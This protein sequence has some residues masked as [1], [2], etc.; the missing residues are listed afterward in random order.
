MNTKSCC[1]CKEQKELELFAKNRNNK[2]GR[3]ARCRACSKIYKE[4]WDK[5]NTE[6]I[7]D[8]SLKYKNNPDVILRRRERHLMQYQD[9]IVREKL[10]E[11]NRIRRRQ[12]PAKIKQRENERL[13]RLNNPNYRIRQNLNNRL[14]YLLFNSKKD[15]IVSYLGCPIKD[16]IKH[17]ESTWK[18]GMN[19]SNYGRKNGN[20]QIDHIIPLASF[21]LTREEEVNKAFHFTNTQALW[22]IDNLRKGDKLDF[23]IPEITK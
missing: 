4:K 16:F 8:Y 20:W 6:H 5:E 1:V 10:L 18:D 7:K 3:N 14:K 22:K 13:R 21:D 17:I 11:K 19:W 9:P 15:S 23:V 2:D 12:E